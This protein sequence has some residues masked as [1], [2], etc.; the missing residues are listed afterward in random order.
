[1]RKWIQTGQSN[2][3]QSTRW[4]WT[5][6]KCTPPQVFFKTITELFQNGLSELTA[7][8]CHEK[9]CPKR[10][11]NIGKYSGRSPLLAKL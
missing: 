2:L 6:K 10:I 5:Y 9:C 7:L 4:V 8:T 1:M 3:I 11:P